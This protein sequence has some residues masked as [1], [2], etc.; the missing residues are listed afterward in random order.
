MLAYTLDRMLETQL[1]VI[2]RQINLANK[3]GAMETEDWEVLPSVPCKF[4]W[5][6]SES[7][8]GTAREYAEPERKVNLRGGILIVAL[9]TDVT[10]KDRVSSI[11]DGEGNILIDTG[12]FRIVAVEQQASHLELSLYQP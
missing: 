5:W 1:A 11:T 4:S 9:G 6:H 10:D 7:G 12:P 3:W 8:R 2:E